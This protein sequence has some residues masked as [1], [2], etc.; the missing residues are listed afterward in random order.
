MSKPVNSLLCQLNI[1]LD[2]LNRELSNV[3]YVEYSDETALSIADKIKIILNGSLP[4]VKHSYVNDNTALSD[5]DYDFLV[6]YFQTRGMRYLNNE[7]LDNYREI[8]ERRAR[9]KRLLYEPSVI[10]EKGYGW[11]SIVKRRQAAWRALS[12][13]QQM[14]LL[15]MKMKGLRPYQIMET[16][17]SAF[18]AET[19][20]F[21]ENVLGGTVNQLLK[22]DETQ[23]R[24]YTIEDVTGTYDFFLDKFINGSKQ[25]E[26]MGYIEQLFYFKWITKYGLGFW[27]FKYLF[28]QASSSRFAFSKETFNQLYNWYESWRLKSKEEK[29]QEEEKAHKL[30]RAKRPAVRRKVKVC[31]DYETAIMSGRINGTDDSFGF[32]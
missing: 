6:C 9:L 8:I 15:C 13:R 1:E 29:K 20:S 14:E 28:P 11:R 22:I 31:P 3:E 21:R 27:S 30:A 16:L 24:I 25:I 5:A 4:I 26:K 32:E 7:E 19:K 10:L 17:E 23:Q 18:N 12:T 2:T